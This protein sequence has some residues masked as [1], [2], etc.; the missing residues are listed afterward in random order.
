VIYDGKGQVSVTTNK[1][2]KLVINGQAYAV[3]AGVSSYSV[4]PLSAK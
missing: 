4:K 2:Y 3:P 1:P